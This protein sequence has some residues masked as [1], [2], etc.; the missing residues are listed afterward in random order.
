MLAEG[1]KRSFTTSVIN[2]STTIETIATKVNESRIKY[3]VES[4]WAIRNI[5]KAGDVET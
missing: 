5:T 1:K 2:H 3:T 4:S